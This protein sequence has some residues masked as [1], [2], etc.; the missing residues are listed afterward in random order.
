LRTQKIFGLMTIF[1]LASLPLVA[2]TAHIF[3]KPNSILIFFLMV[4]V[5]LALFGTAYFVVG[6]MARRKPGTG[7]TMRS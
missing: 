6:R 3:G 1:A 2:I 7:K 4:F 5:V